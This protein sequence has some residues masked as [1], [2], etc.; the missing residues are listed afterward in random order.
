M[1][2]WSVSA[3]VAPRT[4]STSSARLTNVSTGAARASRLFQRRSASCSLRSQSLELNT[5]AYNHTAL[6]HNNFSLSTRIFQVFVFD[7]KTTTVTNDT[8][9]EASVEIVHRVLQ[10]L[11]V[12]V[13]AARARDLT[14]HSVLALQHRLVVCC[15]S[16]MCL[17]K[18]PV[19]NCQGAQFLASGSTRY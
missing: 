12:R 4:L 10:R 1:C 9:L 19:S 3:G 2:V 15:L 17:Q 8:D 5:H 11:H 14:H 16:K 7:S 18:H 6:F 13:S